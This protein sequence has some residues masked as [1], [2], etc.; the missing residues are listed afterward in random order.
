MRDGRIKLESKRLETKEGAN[1]SECEEDPTCADLSDFVRSL[2]IDLE[3]GAGDLGAAAGKLGRRSGSRLLAVRNGETETETPNGTDHVSEDEPE[4]VS[5]AAWK[6]SGSDALKGPVAIPDA[7]PCVDNRTM[8]SGSSPQSA[9]FVTPA[10]TRS[11]EVGTPMCATSQPPSC[12]MIQCNTEWVAPPSP[13]CTLYG[14]HPSQEGLPMGPAVMV[15]MGLPLPE[16]GGACR[17]LCVTEV[18]KTSSACAACTRRREQKLDPAQQCR[19]CSHIS[20]R[21]RKQGIQVEIIQLVS[22]MFDTYNQTVVGEFSR[23]L[24]PTHLPLTRFCTATTGISTKEAEA[25]EPLEQVLVA[26][27]QWVQILLG[28]ANQM[29]LVT[30]GDF[31]CDALIPRQCERVPMPVPHYMNRWV[32][33]KHAFE[34]LHPTK[35]GPIS[36]M[37]HQIGIQVDGSGH[38]AINDCRMMVYLLENILQTSE[39]GLPPPRVKYALY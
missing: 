27:A 19:D 20:K 28:H 25:A 11:N 10:M 35:A 33:I 31:L 2:G 32:N 14:P 16:Y 1:P 37:C 30:C 22:S 24:R 29:L 13:A 39:Q 6:G 18:A 5:A 3:D 7:S 23:L 26:H 36:Q 12:G 4:I 38:H 17:Y 21:R 8:L 15:P 34:A 9:L